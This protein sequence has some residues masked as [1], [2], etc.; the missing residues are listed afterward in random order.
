MKKIIIGTLILFLLMGMVVATDINNLKMPDKWESV[1]SG[2]YHQKDPV[3]NGGNGHN[4][5][6][7]KWLDSFKDEW[8][9]NNSAEA[10]AVKSYGENTYV[11]AD[12]D[13]TGCFEV[14]EIDGQKYFVNFWTVNN[15]DVEKIADTSLFMQE[16]NQLNN[17]EPVEV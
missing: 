2:S 4:M 5:M 17:L 10:Y 14:V 8:Y 13:T 6:I 1:S 15:M 11:Y 7:Q 3:T 9:N 12:P 16:F